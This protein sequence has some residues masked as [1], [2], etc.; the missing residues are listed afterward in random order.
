M[1]WMTDP[2]MYGIQNADPLNM[3]GSE[4]FTGISDYPEDREKFP[5]IFLDDFEEIVHDVTPFTIP[6]A[7]Y[8]TLETVYDCQ[9]ENLRGH[10]YRGTNVP[11]WAASFFHSG[12]DTP[13]YLWGHC[14]YNQAGYVFTAYSNLGQPVQFV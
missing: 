9:R 3:P 1:N 4:Y 11:V 10:A 2:F 7:L 12:W 13:L 8:S 6:D 14:G 5:F